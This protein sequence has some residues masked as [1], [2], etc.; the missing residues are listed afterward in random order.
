MGK[1]LI[2]ALVVYLVVVPLLVSAA[3]AA[4]EEEFYYF[5]FA[6]IFAASNSAT[7]LEHKM[8]A[9]LATFIVGVFG[10]CLAIFGM[11]EF[12][13]PLL[14][15]FGSVAMCAISILYIIPDATRS[16]ESSRIGDF[17]MTRLVA[18]AAAILTMI[19]TKS[20]FMIRNQTVSR[21]DDKKI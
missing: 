18:M 9:I 21:Q 16:L 12:F 10:V 13:F 4:A 6:P 14:S 7:A 11:D 17:R 20:I 8:K 2:S 3:A 19:E 15:H 1:T 5:G